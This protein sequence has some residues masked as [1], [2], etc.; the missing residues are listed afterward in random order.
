[1]QIAPPFH[2]KWRAGQPDG[3]HPFAVWFADILHS[4][5]ETRIPE[6]AQH[7]SDV[8]GTHLEDSPKFLIEER[9]SGF[10]PSACDR[11]ELDQCAAVPRE[12]HFAWHD[13]KPAARAVVV[14]EEQAVAVQALDDREGTL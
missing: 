6:R 8:I 14:C 12:D 9:G 7:L 1:M 3:Q 2:K 4:A 13:E 11:V 10:V 5:I